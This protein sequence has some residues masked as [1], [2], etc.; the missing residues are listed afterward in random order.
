MIRLLALDLDDTLLGTD[1]RISMENMRA[2][3][4]ARA[5]GVRVTVVTGRRWIAARPYVRQIRPELPVICYCGAKVVHPETEKT[6]E[7]HLLPGRLVERVLAFLAGT[8]H[9]YALYVDDLLY[10]EVWL[11]LPSR[12]PEEVPPGVQVVKSVPDAYRQLQAEQRDGVP[13]P[14]IDV[15]GA[16]AAEAVLAAFAGSG[17]TEAGV[18]LLP[19]RS[20]NLTYLKILPYAAEKGLAL[21]RLCQRYGI[22]PGEVAA[23]G[24]S[25]LDAGMLRYAGVGV[26]MPWSGPEVKA[27]ADLVMEEGEPHPVAAAIRRLLS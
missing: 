15:F 23:M 3:E 12:G 4:E 16:E 13:V 7:L 20:E 17:R 26:A 24:D 27:A 2:L 5:K 25:V 9:R 21:G 6:E 22:E 14:Q 19:L 11:T 8:S 18:R 1:G 10:T